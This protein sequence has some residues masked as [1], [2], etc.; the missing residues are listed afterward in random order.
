[1]AEPFDRIEEAWG[2]AWNNLVQSFWILPAP[3]LSRLKPEDI[4]GYTVAVPVW[5]DV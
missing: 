1:M 4:M 2:K 3:A 5:P